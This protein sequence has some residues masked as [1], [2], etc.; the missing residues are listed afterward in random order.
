MVSKQDNISK[1]RVLVQELENTENHTSGY[2][3]IIYEIETLI[4][5]EIKEI[6]KLKKPDNKIKHY[7][8]ICAGILTIISSTRI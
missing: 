2:S 7:E 5:A 3:D 4:N 6:S 1:L 8:N